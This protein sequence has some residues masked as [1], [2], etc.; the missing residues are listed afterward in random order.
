MR[1]PR[2]RASRRAKRTWAAQAPAPTALTPRKTVRGRLARALMA[3]RTDQPPG[4]AAARGGDGPREEEK[5]RAAEGAAGA[6]DRCLA[7]AL[8]DAAMLAVMQRV[9]RE[10]RA[11][12]RAPSIC[13]ARGRRRAE[14]AGAET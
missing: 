6:G 4:M 11:A 14:G 10:E 5:A 12:G 13:P 9:A 1:Q 8:G 7:Y 3:W 2:F